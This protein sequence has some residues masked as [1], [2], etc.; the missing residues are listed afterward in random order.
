MGGTMAF[1]FAG[2]FSSE[3]V[4]IQLNPSLSF[5]FQSRMKMS[6]TFA[7]HGY[8]RVFDV[9]IR[10]KRY[11]SYTDRAKPI[12]GSGGKLQVQVMSP[13]LVERAKIFND[14][15]QVRSRKWW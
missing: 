1:W 14:T 10:L 9:S 7:H 3:M 13:S 15:M 2:P 8:S 12:L 4:N 6:V 5:H 11:D